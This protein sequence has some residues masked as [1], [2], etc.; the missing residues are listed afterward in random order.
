[1]ITQEDKDNLIL[2][3][4]TF[5]KEKAK[6]YNLDMAFLY[7]SW[8]TGYPREDSDVDLAVLFSSQL[9]SDDEIFNIIMDISYNLSS[10]I[11]KEVNILPIYRDFRK[12]LV[13][14]NAIILSHPIYIKDFQEYIKL[15]NEAIF[16]MEDFSI[17]GIKWQ[18]EMT[19]KNLEALQ[20]G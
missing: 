12:P 15:K 7:G 20:Y 5:F 2:S 10:K 11:K 18:I 14:Y 19:R 9:L 16:Q 3:L 6:D 4:K 8:A 13:Y 1:M 17:F